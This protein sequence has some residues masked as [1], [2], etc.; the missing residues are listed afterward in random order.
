MGSWRLHQDVCLIGPVVIFLDRDCEGTVVL[1]C[2]FVLN[3]PPVI[4]QVE[5]RTE[6]ENS[7]SSKSRVS[8]LLHTCIENQPGGKTV[9]VQFSLERARVS[10]ICGK[11]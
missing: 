8:I 11:L 10:Q 5:E 7:M 4:G 1:T 6:N 2:G 3:W 9:C